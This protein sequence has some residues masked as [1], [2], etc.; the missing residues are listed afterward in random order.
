MTDADVQPEPVITTTTSQNTADVE[1]Q[2]RACLEPQ[3]PH[4][5][6]PFDELALRYN[7]RKT[8]DR[9]AML[10]RLIINELKGRPGPTRVLDIGAG[11]GIGRQIAF[12][13]AIARHCDELWGVEPDQG[14]TQP[15]GVFTQYQ[16][17]MMETAELP[18]NA[19]DVAYAFMVMEHVADPT[20]FLSALK[21]CL[22][23]GGVFLFMTPNR[24]HYFTR[25]ANL[26]KTLKIDELTLRI[27]RRQ[28]DL[29]EYHYPVV[30]RFNTPEQIDLATR[31]AG[32][33]RP[34][35]VYL[36]SVGPRP[37]MRGPLLPIFYLLMYKRSIIKNPRV[38]LTLTGRIAKPLSNEDEGVVT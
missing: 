26:L 12:Q 5:E 36:E 16:H 31:N 29:D 30:Y 33:E 1:S 10:V 35:Y 14:I 18:E 25:S 20:A 2:W 8:S 28:G 19:F 9:R 32:M 17:A 27:L 15:D 3:R 22:K 34:G 11:K 13:R 7:F 37:Y 24:R 21:R 6:L 4:D 38:L 23:P